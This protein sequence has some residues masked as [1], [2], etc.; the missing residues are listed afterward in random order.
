MEEQGKCRKTRI[1]VIT[2][3]A[4]DFPLVDLHV[5]R[6]R[7]EVE[8]CSRNGE[9]KIVLDL[10]NVS[11]LDSAGLETLIDAQESLQKKGG[12][13][14]IVHPNAICKDA[15]IATRLAERLEIFSDMEIAGKSF[16]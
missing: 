11:C 8:T 15:L 12:T 2:F 16:L 4:P 9:V 6:L 3:L 1:G 10:K 5:G 7:E 13:L 14:K